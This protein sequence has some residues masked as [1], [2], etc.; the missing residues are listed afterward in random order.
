MKIKGFLQNKKRRAAVVAVSLVT[1]A[2]LAGGAVVYWIRKDGS[3][4]F[5]FEQSGIGAWNA[6]GGIVSASGVTN[7]GM[8]QE[9][10]QVRT[11]TGLLV[12]EV[13][14]GANDEVEAGDKVL[15]LSEESVSD[16]RKELEDTLKEAQ[17]A[18]RAG[19][20]AYKQS[21]ITAACDRD[22]ALLG[23]EQALEIYEEAIDGLEESAA[24]AQKELADAEE[25][26]ETYKS[27][28]GG[29]S[30][31]EDYEVGKYKDLYDENLKLLT[32]K[33]EE[34]KVGWNQITQG[35]GSAGNTGS[36]G[37]GGIAPVSLSAQSVSGGDGQTDNGGE[38][39]ETQGGMQ[40]GGQGSGNDGYV[41][42][43]SALY[44]VLEQNLKDY[45]QALS[46]YEDA[47]VNAQFELQTLEL[48]LSTLQKNLAQAKESGETE[49][50]NARLTLEKSLAGGERAESDYETAIEKSKADFEAL[51]DAWE[52]A[53]ENLEQFESSV[54]DGYYYASHK[55]T[56]L[57]SMIKT[58]Q[59]LTSE[60]TVFV[61]SNPQEMTVSVAVDQGEIANVAVG[62][63][64]LVQSSQFGTFQGSV[65]AIDPVS[66]SESRTSVTYNV[67]VTL[68]GDL[69]EL[70]GNQSVSVVLGIGETVS[71]G[72]Q[73]SIMGGS[74]G[75]EDMEVSE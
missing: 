4:Q 7:V 70:M 36:S 14:I 30:F 1:A 62:D 18:Y 63:S 61:Y 25:K 34:W 42:V 29:N 41:S 43:L 11:D 13:Y 12:E 8:V 10:Y 37:G 51:K 74:P 68:S 22:T 15:K 49:K 23:K 67:T 58:G 46:E 6:G 73:I 50:L 17:L 39:Q 55:G 45:E 16:V 31:Y 35:S 20:I 71:D 3:V 54:G 60:G 27:A 21:Q 28:I 2:V 69:G 66:S 57:R 24:S 56:V 72:N 5:P 53:E 65:T 26:I 19:A 75:F 47:S 9:N 48:G 33:M 44:S 32:S 59:Y 38:Q 64:A 52:D 40:N